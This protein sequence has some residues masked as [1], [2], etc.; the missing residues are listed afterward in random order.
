MS[1]DGG[2]V[3]DYRYQDKF[4]FSPTLQASLSDMPVTP[5]IQTFT[6]YALFTVYRPTVYGPTV[7]IISAASPRGGETIR[8]SDSSKIPPGKPPGH[9]RHS[10]RM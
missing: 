8:G 2:H 5:D 10:P 3:A 4:R 1:G 6:F 9:Q 7:P